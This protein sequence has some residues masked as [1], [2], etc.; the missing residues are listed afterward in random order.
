[1]NVAIGG[2]VVVVGNRSF[3]GYTRKRFVQYGN[4]V[5]VFTASIL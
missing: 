4:S 3:C 2:V 1:M 5:L